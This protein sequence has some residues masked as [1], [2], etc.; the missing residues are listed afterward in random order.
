M[1]ATLEFEMRP[2]SSS[3][4]WRA[5]WAANAFSEV[6]VARTFMNVT[7][8]GATLTMWWDTQLA[9]VDIKVG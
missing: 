8:Q 7:P 2:R 1:E 4:I 9:S 3:I 6:S 5:F